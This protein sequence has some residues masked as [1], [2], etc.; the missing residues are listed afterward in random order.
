[1]AI[2]HKGELKVG[3][4]V[5]I[6][7]GSITNILSGVVTDRIN[8]VV[9]TG[10]DECYLGYRFY[11]RCFGWYGTTTKIVQTKYGDPMTIAEYKTYYRTPEAKAKRYATYKDKA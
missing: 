1:M 6:I 8:I 4:N 3:N 11:V 7:S 9:F 10:D 5:S 2:L